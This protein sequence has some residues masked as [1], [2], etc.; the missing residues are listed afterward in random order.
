MQD[1]TQ[2]ERLFIEILRGLD[3]QRREDLMRIIEVLTKS[4]DQNKK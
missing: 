1:L 4:T 2:F 3:K